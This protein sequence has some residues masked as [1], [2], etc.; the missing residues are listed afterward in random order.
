MAARGTPGVTM[1]LV[2]RRVV[3]GLVPT[4]RGGVFAGVGVV[5]LVAAV[6]VA[7]TDLLL[8]ALVCLLAVAASA[9][10]ARLA[11][12]RA[13]VAR[14]FHPAAVQAGES[15]DVRLEVTAS[16]R[17][18]R[19]ATWR[20]VL[21]P[22][23][24]GEA[25]GAV[26]E[27]RAPGGARVL[28]YTAVARVRG[29]HP[30]GPL[31]VSSGD[32]LGLVVGR[33]PVG[34]ASTL[35]VT[36][37]VVPLT[38]VPRVP[39]GDG[40]EDLVPIRAQHSADALIAREYRR[41]DPMR[42][43]DWRQTARRGALMVRQEESRTDP[44]AILVIDPVGPVGGAE[45]LDAALDVAASVAVHLLH[46]GFALHVV[47]T[48]SAVPALHPASAGPDE[49]L[50]MLARLPASRVGD[51]LVAHAVADLVRA[52][53]EGVPVVVVTAGEL[54]G[55]TELVAQVSAVHGAGVLLAPARAAAARAAATAARWRVG[56]VGGAS[57]PA[58]VWAEAVATRTEPADVR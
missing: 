5:L 19:H 47:T 20:D 54:A 35:V 10:E 42:R 28:A 1:R 24:T 40:R 4:V 58:A 53:G 39:D 9:L 36:P 44:R 27:H 15:V 45:G 31:L 52:E 41:G 7:R 57:D 29:E 48:D 23:V 21:P 37:R 22:A 56:T 33:A 12:P 14:T 6:V 51:P 11:A 17:W 2:V 16:R 32:S 38:G 30:I 55:G 8:V 43:V 34:G 49:L 25:V 18:P 26:P 3:G 13:R 46:A 50:G